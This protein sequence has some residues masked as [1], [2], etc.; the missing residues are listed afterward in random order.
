M[1]DQKKLEIATKTEKITE[2]SSI[3]DELMNEILSSD[4]TGGFPKYM[5]L[6]E[7][8]PI[9]I[10]VEDFS[11]V[12][13]YIKRA[14]S[15]GVGDISTHLKKNP[16]IVFKLLE[17]TRVIDVN[18]RTLDLFNANSK[19]DLLGNLGKV[20]SNNSINIFVDEIVAMDKGEMPYCADFAGKT[21]DGKPIWVSL[22]VSIPDEARDTWSTV[23]VSITDLTNQKKG[24]IDLASSN[25]R[26]K[27]RNIELESL[28][29]VSQSL[30]SENDLDELLKNISRSVVKVLPNAEAS[31]LWLVDKHL[32][33]LHVRSWSG[34]SSDEIKGLSLAKTKSA[35]WKVFSSMKPILI[36]DTSKDKYFKDFK[37]PGLDKPR[38]LMGVPIL[39]GDKTLG[40]LFADNFSQIDAFSND[41][42]RLLIAFA[43]NIV[44]A[45]ENTRL[46]DNERRR[47]AALERSNILLST[48]GK[49]AFQFGSEIDPDQVFEIFSSEL[50]EI[51]IECFVSLFHSTEQEFSLKYVSV[52]PGLLKK[53][54]KAMGRSFLDLS[55]PKERILQ[56]DEMMMH[57]R[58]VYFQ[59]VQEAALLM[60]PSMPKS[61]AKKLLAMGRMGPGTPAINAPLLVD[62]ML[63]GIIGF[64]GDQIQ[65]EDKL[66]Y[67]IFASQV[68]TS[69]AT[70]KLFAAVSESRGDLQDSEAKYQTLVDNVPLGIYRTT[71][72][73]NGGLVQS[74]PALATMFGYKSTEDLAQV[75]VNALYSDPS[76][77]HAFI[78]ELKSRGSVRN[79]EIRLVKKNKST[80]LA[81]INSVSTFGA[82]GEL[83]WIDGII[84]DVTEKK[85]IENQMV[86]DAFHDGLT[87]LPNRELFFDRLD[88]AVSRGNRRKDYLYAVL[89]IDLD[90]FK[91]VNDSMGHASGDVALL[92]I[93]TNLKEC[94]REGDTVARF[95]GDEFVVLLDDIRNEATALSIAGRMNE[96]LNEQISIGSS[97]IVVTGTIGVAIKPARAS[98]P[99][100]LIRAAD[101]AM[102]RAKALG[103]NRYEVFDPDMLTSAINRLKVENGIRAGLKNKQFAVYYQPIINLDTDM[104]AGVEALVRW[105]HPEKGVLPPSEFLKVAEETGLILDLGN[106]VLHEACLQLNEW[107]RKFK[108]LQNLYVSINLSQKQLLDPKLITYVKAA[109]SF[110]KLNTRS[111]T[112]EITED[113][114][115]QD[116][117]AAR[118]KLKKMAN[119]G[120]IIDM[121]DF[122]KGYSSLSTLNSLPFNAIKIDQSFIRPIQEDNN[123]TAFVRAIVSLAQELDM[124]TI[125]EGIESEFQRKEL[126]KIGC[127]YGQGYY[128]AKPLNK[129]SA[130]EFI[131]KTNEQL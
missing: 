91:V 35:L 39:Q 65:E 12:K 46:L 29:Q 38:S 130:T 80:F 128:F 112:I 57:K 88:R 23:F 31:S 55:I 93:A 122:G 42:E 121:D 119:M 102:Y 27:Q 126:Q 115:M 103:K 129:E 111:L 4:I 69:L 49:V 30:H 32:D 70:A 131:K 8:A 44:S 67:S 74:N 59:E 86:H 106:F 81:N 90:R 21:I 63:V 87:G 33:K 36:K 64:W 66:A 26:L 98:K 7:D 116:I 107:Q 22:Q 73:D 108:G 10:W 95:A 19:D 113:A 51:G 14:K 99:E 47:A 50:S 72:S 77:R 48:L 94:I 25:Q 114:I 53:M 71:G 85:R 89:F 58:P 45:I 62:D 52:K 82:D 117:S 56:F 125:A 5:T 110:S 3:S 101:I 37:Q 120:L 105:I 61:M 13:K 28:S 84:E 118:D 24:E 75:Q 41:D 104:L 11:E 79:K 18:E 43:S 83:K 123:N 20:I 109:L 15:Q 92:S 124:E 17:K 34:H 16:K 6:F 127:K 54:E 60:L 9:S 40:V 76:D 78:D 96:K 100:D 1:T 97:E 2:I 68:S